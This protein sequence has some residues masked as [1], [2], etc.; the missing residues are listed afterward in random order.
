MGIVYRNEV[1]KPNSIWNVFYSY[2]ECAIA[3]CKTECQERCRE[4]YQILD[5]FEIRRH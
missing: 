4:P 3:K 1:L 5:Y 2:H